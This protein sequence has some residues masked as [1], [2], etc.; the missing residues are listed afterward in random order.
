[1]ISSK[2]MTTSE[3]LALVENNKD[4]LKSFSQQERNSVIDLIE[5]ISA[6]KKK[7]ALLRKN[8]SPYKDYLFEDLKK[9]DEDYQ[10][11]MSAAEDLKR[12]HI[13]HILND[14]KRKQ[15]TLGNAI[16]LLTAANGPAIVELKHC[17][18]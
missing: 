14:G 13:S 17:V 4:I 9:K 5:D 2:T 10:A 6:I 15:A 8:N 16:S 18:N 7:E 12:K 11:R 1:M 3:A